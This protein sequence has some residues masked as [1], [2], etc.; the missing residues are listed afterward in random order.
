[1]PRAL[2]NVLDISVGINLVADLAAGNN[3]GK[4]FHMRNY[5]TLG[6]L[7]YKN[8]ASAG[9][10]DIV[11][12]L[13]E[14]NAASGGTLQ[15]LSAITDVYYK[16]IASPLV[17]TEVWTE[18]TQ[19]KGSTFTIAGASFATFQGMWYFDVDAA[20]M[21]DG[22]QWLSLDIADPGSGGTINGGVFYIATE[23]KIL[24]KPDL[25]AQPNA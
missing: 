4:R 20:S 17:G 11:L 12:T 21:S 7:F 3:T 9:S 6:I 5:E 1:M 24:R 25:L 15:A 19:A 8:A 16:A 22:F 14:S 18:V 23:L 2:G 10:D 13:K